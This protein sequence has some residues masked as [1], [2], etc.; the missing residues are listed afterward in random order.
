MICNVGSQSSV[1]WLALSNRR[2]RLTRYRRGSADLQEER[3]WYLNEV[4]LE[5]RIVLGVCVSF[6]ILGP[7]GNP[8]RVQP[9]QPRWPERIEAAQPQAGVGRVRLDPTEG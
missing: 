9:M 1:C 8:V 5:R 4:H 6:E 3:L 2:L 7:T